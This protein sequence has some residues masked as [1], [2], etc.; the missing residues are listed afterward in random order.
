M[1]GVILDGTPLLMDYSMNDTREFIC[2]Y[3]KYTF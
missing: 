2:Q 3:G 1:G